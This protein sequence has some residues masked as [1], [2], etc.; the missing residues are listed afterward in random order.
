MLMADFNVD[1]A[2]RANRFDP[3]RVTTVRLIHGE[4]PFFDAATPDGFPVRCSRNGLGPT[5]ATCPYSR[6]IDRADIV[7]RFPRDWL[8]DW[9]AL[10][11][12]IERLIASLRP[13]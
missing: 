2:F 10:D 1:V 9:C 4:D 13:R 11:A 7:V 6:R 12:G 5:P 8:T 3:D